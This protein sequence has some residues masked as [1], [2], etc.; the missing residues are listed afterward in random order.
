M[1]NEITQYRIFIA[2]P[3]DTQKEREIV[4]KVVKEINQNLGSIQ[5]FNI[6]TLRWENDVIPGFGDDGQDVI[7]QEIGEE[8]DFFIG[9]MWKRFGSKTNR[10]E[11]G[12]VEEFEAA[13]KRRES[14]QI[15]IY[16]NNMHIP[17]EGFD[18]DQYSKVLE[19]RAKVENLGGFYKQYNSYEDFESNIRQ[20]LTQKITQ[21]HSK[22]QQ[23]GPKAE[24]GYLTPK[25]SA[26]YESFLND[27][28]VVF[29]H[30][31]VDHITLEDIYIPPVL[32]VMQSDILKKTSVK[33]FIE[34]DNLAKTIKGD[35]FKYL[36]IGSELSGKS[37]GCKYL[38]KSYYDRGYFPVLINGKD[39]KDSIRPVELNKLIQH[40]ADIQYDASLKICEEKRDRVILIIDDFNKATK[41]KSKYWQT[42][43]QNIES[44][45]SK[46]ILTG[47]NIMPT[48]STPKFT[49]FENFEIYCLNEFGPKLRKELVE[50]WLRLGLDERLLDQNDLY[51]KLDETLAYVKTIIGKN[52]IPSFPFYILTILQALEIGKTKD[53]SYSIHGFYYEMLINDSLRKAIKNKDDISLYLN[54]LTN[55]F[56]Q[57]FIS[58][59]R[60]VT[61]HEFNEFF[62]SYAEI[63]EIPNKY[64]AQE[65]LI[66][67]EKAKIIKIFNNGVMPKENYIYYFFVS[68]FLANNINKKGIDKDIKDIIAKMCSRVFREEY[69]SILL[70]LTHLSKDEYVIDQ[71]LVSAESIFHDIEP[72]KLEGDVTVVNSMIEKL[73]A[74]VMAL[75]DV[76]QK[77]NEEIEEEDKNARLEKE[78]EGETS[79]YDDIGLDDDINNIDLYAKLNLALKTIDILGQ[80]AKKHW[81]ELDG[82]QKLTLVSTTYNLGRRM[83]GYYLNNVQNNSEA[84]AK[85]IEQIIEKK[86][87]KDRY[88]LEHAVKNTAREFIFRLC[89]LAT[90]GTTKRIANAIGYE[91]L[92]STFEKILQSDEVNSIRLIDLA[93]KLLNPST[94]V[95]Q[96]KEYSQL[97]KDN[98]L[99]FLMLQNLYIDHIYLF[100]SNHKIKAQMC[101]FLEISI[102]RQ[103]YIDTISKV[104]K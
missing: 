47:I 27:V 52:Y 46:I 88:K 83:L 90:W 98:H 17:Q 39:F 7:N 97:M 62:I 63:H 80:I 31:R 58:Q 50:A 91:N 41:G 75:V 22:T 23:N 56:Y 72:I 73:P 61:I 30:S 71:I 100:E 43:I 18:I 1:K 36:L 51:K 77:R 40:H 86:H 68:R 64:S 81:G 53:T 32:E 94:P 48:Q 12:T 14:I 21:I 5:R 15:M 70:F 93:I 78:F 60:F 2:S 49:A 25:L 8:Y 26:E 74:Q 95:E 20:H 11:S 66:N 19:F 9:I 82:K 92:N 103:A 101:E 104:R 85:Q 35:S 28:E 3:S 33:S 45:Y 6:K 54:F 29:A 10:A 99:C 34:L 65:I 57:F 84:L 38:Y 55:L 37:A 76:N 102:E 44:E 24:Q 69:A 4:E 16:F 13:Y 89:F 87:I 96:I 42:L 79:N 59:V 67:L